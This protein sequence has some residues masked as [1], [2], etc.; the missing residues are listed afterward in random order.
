MTDTEGLLSEEL[1]EENIAPSEP[2]TPPAK[3]KESIEDEEDKTDNATA[4]DDL[5]QDVNEDIE[6]DCEDFIDE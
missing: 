5:V 6:I 1:H 4:Y 3:T 2:P